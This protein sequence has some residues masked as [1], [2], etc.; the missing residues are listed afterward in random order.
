MLKFIKIT[1]IFLFV[2]TLFLLN[3][4]ILLAE[5]ASGVSQNQPTINFVP[6]VN[7][8]GVNIT[9][10]DL[11]QGTAIGKYVAGL[12]NYATAIVGII[13]AIILMY[14]GIIWI[15][16]GG[17]MERISNAKAWISAA[18]SGLILV[19]ATY[20]ILYIVNPNLLKFKAIKINLISSNK[21]KSESGATNI[22]DQLIA[23]YECSELLGSEEAC[24]Q[25]CN[26]TSSFLSAQPIDINGS[27]QY[28][29]HCQQTIMVNACCL[30]GKSFQITEGSETGLNVFE[31]CE[32]LKNVPLD[33]LTKKCR[34]FKYTPID[35]EGKDWQCAHP[36]GS[37][38]Y[39]CE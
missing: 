19:M 28:C 2:L 22:K 37:S 1:T 31:K 3:P 35:G 34:A 12:Y 8:P 10:T 5:N 15:T 4:H 16:A 20:T 32:N 29:C 26:K 36:E 30:S 18:L 6:Q 24:I 38:Y 14:G 7:I 27:T 21:S 13:A 25:F 9:S 39:Y 11:T 17:N 33:E 23:K